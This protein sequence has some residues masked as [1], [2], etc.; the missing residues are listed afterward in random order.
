M[1]KPSS[2]TVII[3]RRNSGKG[4]RKDDKSHSASGCSLYHQ[5][6]CHVLW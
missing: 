2:V 3:L 1:D 4:A 6:Y 5:P